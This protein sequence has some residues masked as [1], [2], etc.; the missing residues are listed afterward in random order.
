M[1]LLLAPQTGDVLCY[2]HLL[3]GQPALSFQCCLECWQ[4]KVGCSEYYEQFEAKDTCA[5]PSSFN[6]KIGKRNGKLSVNFM[7]AMTA[8][9]QQAAKQKA[10]P[11]T[12]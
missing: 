10:K 1:S 4:L 2:I 12:K 9:D 3:I 7:M 8:S 5:A 6:P 11:P